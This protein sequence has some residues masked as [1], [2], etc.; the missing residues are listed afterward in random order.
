VGEREKKSLLDFD[1]EADDALDALVP[2]LELD[3]TQVEERAT[4][5]PSFDPQR[6]ADESELRARM[7]TI[8]NEDLLEAARLATLKTAP[9]VRG[10][11]SGT[12]TAPPT[13][14]AVTAPPASTVTAPPAGDLDALE[15]MDEGEQI[16]FFVKR[17]SPTAR[18]PELARPVAQL[19]SSISDP[20]TAY[21]AGFVDG[22]L[23]LETIVDVTG[24]PQLEPLRILDKMVSQGIIVFR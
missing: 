8:S 20:K 4:V 14:G 6:L 16:A 19:G 10:A 21:V 18:V 2:R 9:P 17:L 13:G 5:I 24:L 7:P 15:S 22:V 12:V 11:V 23:P 1:A 3:E